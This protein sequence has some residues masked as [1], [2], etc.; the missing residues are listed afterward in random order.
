VEAHRPVSDY[1]IGLP[2][3]LRPVA[4]RWNAVPPA[5]RQ[6]LAEFRR[7]LAARLGDRLRETRLFG[8]YAR[9][10]FTDESDVDVLVLADRLHPAEHRAIV[11]EAVLLGLAVL[12]LAPERLQALR[13]RE[14]L[15]AQDIDHEG[16]PL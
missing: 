5:V 12:I 10:D 6:A 9:G 4:D 15:I 16:I 3:T 7:A 13:A 1:D 2:A 8:S 14:L 11:D